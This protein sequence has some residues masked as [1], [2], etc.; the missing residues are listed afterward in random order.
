RARGEPT[1][2]EG[3]DRAAPSRSTANAAGSDGSGRGRGPDLPTHRRAFDAADEAR[4]HPCDRSAD[5]AAHQTLAKLRECM[6]QLEPRE[7]RAEAHGLAHPETDVRIRVTVDAER[8]GF[9]EDLL[10]A[11]P[12]RVEETDRLARADRLSAQLD[13]G[14]RGPRELDDRRRPT[15]DFLD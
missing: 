9:R 13:V 12:R 14:R 5:L 10:V 3:R 1:D 15:H 2:A 6:A 8:E 11:I 4:P 7:V